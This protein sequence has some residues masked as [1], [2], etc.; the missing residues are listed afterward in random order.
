MLYVKRV[1]FLKNCIVSFQNKRVRLSRVWYLN[2]SLELRASYYL[3]SRWSLKYALAHA[4]I[5]YIYMY[6]NKLK[7]SEWWATVLIYST[8]IWIRDSKVKQISFGKLSSLQKDVYD[9]IFHN[10]RCAQNIM[11]QIFTNRTT[12]V[13]PGF[14]DAWKS[15]RI[16][17]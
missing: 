7:L 8:Y 9:L 17:K 16:H 6:I 15:K 3:Y 10:P 14:Y 4:I 1:P 13:R 2:L 11:W 5:I 12:Y